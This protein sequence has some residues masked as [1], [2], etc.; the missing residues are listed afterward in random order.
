MENSGTE[1]KWRLLVTG[2][3]GFIGFNFCMLAISRGYDVTII[4]NL[5]REGS[6]ENKEYLERWCD[7]I[8]VDPIESYFWLDNLDISSYKAVVHLAAQTA[9]TT[10]VANPWE[11]FRTNAHGTFNLLTSL[12]EKDFQGLFINVASNKVYGN[13]DCKLVTEETRYTTVNR[14]PGFDENTQ[15]SGCTPYGVSKLCADQYALDFANT[16]GMN[17]ISLR[18]SCIYGENQNGSFDQG[19]LSHFSKLIKKDEPVKICGDGKQVRDILHVDDLVDLY[20]KLIEG[21]YKEMKG[22]AFNVGGGFENSV[23]ILETL[24]D[25]EIL[26]DRKIEKE[27]LP[28]RPN[29]QRYYVSD[30][31]KVARI[32]GWVPKISSMQGLRRLCGV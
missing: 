8:I 3:C 20:L 11:D 10:S 6:R 24:Y 25:M 12:Q 30:N 5:S 2:G 4:D 19:W 15:L 27:F 7:N 31:A 9:V 14:K 23:S 13:I 1:E 22:Q 18:Q 32:A 16:Y 21:N 26:L 29:D 28:W 17:T